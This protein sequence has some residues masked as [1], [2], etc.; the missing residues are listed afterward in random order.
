MQIPEPIAQ[1]IISVGARM[2]RRGLLAGTDGNI[3]ARIDS[4]RLCITCSGVGKGGL[5]LEDIVAVTTAGQKLAGAKEPS[6]EMLL[7]LFAYRE[8]P[9]VLACVHAHPPFATSFA[10]AGRKLE[11][12]VLPEVVL[13]VG[14]IPLVEY[15]PPGTDAVPAAI[16]PYIKSC[17]AFLFRNHGVLTLGRN[18][19]E[20]YN[21]MET[22]EHY[23]HIL[24]LANQLG[25]VD[26][27][28]ASDMARLR[29]IA[30]NLRT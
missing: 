9:D 6:S 16:A 26:R 24:F 21:R 20:A 10:V 28:P 4:D 13:F 3:S 7:H 29:E 1:E 19:E 17:N 27:I 2:Y 30:R 5:K 15:A 23:A 11:P 25:H 14:E 12:D 18:L 22:V 8:R